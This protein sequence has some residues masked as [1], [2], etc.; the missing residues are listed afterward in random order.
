VLSVVIGFS[1]ALLQDL[2]MF[3]EDFW[4][5]GVLFRFLREIVFPFRDYICWRALFGEARS[6][7][8]LGIFTGRSR[9]L[10]DERFLRD[11]SRS[12][13]EPGRTRYWEGL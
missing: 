6:V 10:R 4:V 1:A 2:S 13:C 3:G 5:W 8:E 9:L 12:G 11:D 7:R